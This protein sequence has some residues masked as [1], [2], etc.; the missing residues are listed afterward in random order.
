MTHIG[1]I[2]LV[3][4]SFEVINFFKL[5]DLIKLNFKSYKK[6]LS[7]FLEKNLDDEAKQ[8]QILDSSKKLLLSS[9]KIIICLFIVLILFFSSKFILNDL[10]NFILSYIGI[11]ETT[12]FFVLYSYLRKYFN[13]KL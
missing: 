9:L 5:I 10:Y 13:A 8:N 2:I 11:L 6:L 7:S 1:L 12:I 3:I 4:I